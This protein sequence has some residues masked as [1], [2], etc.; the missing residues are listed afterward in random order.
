M[1]QKVLRLEEAQ[2]NKKQF[3]IL[4]KP[5]LCDLCRAPSI[6]TQ[7]RGQGVVNTWLGQESQ[8][9]HTVFVEKCK[10]KYP[11]GRPTR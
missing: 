5:K 9:F 4:H 11:N 6:G 10:G 1:G 2:I 8:G 3:Y 7:W